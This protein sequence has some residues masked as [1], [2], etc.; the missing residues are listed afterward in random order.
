[1]G[2]ALEKAAKAYED[3]KKKITDGGQ[4]INTT[5][6]Q[7]IKLGAKQSDR[8]PIPQLIDIDEIEVK[9]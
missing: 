4:S 1:M 6:N 9:E 3:G 2:K 8:N 7:L 5:A